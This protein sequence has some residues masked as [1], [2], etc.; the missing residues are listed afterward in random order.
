M[1]ISGPEISVRLLWYV[2]PQGQGCDVSTLT[3]RKRESP[4]V[5]FNEDRRERERERGNERLRG[6]QTLG[7]H[8]GRN[9]Q[10]GISVIA[11]PRDGYGTRITYHQFMVEFEWRCTETNPVGI[12]NI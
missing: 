1:E 8:G 12:S 4:H 9:C 2:Y 10:Q 11:L 5:Q 3:L 6:H 7:G